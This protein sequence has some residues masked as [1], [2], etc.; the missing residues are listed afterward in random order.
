MSVMQ[1]KE[2]TER[3]AEPLVFGVCAR[4]AAWLGVSAMSVRCAAVI[5]ASAGGFGV[6]VYSVAALGAHRLPVRAARRPLSGDIGVGMV[7]SGVAL[8]LCGSWPGASTAVVVTTIAVLAAV[9]YGWRPI[10]LANR[11]GIGTIMLRVVVGGALMIG[12]A[13]ALLARTDSIDMIATAGVWGLIAVAG[14]AVLAAPGLARLSAAHRSER[15]ARVREAERS[16]VAAHLHDSVLQTLT[17]I[18]RNAGDAQTVSRLARQQ[19]RELRRW[20]YQGDELDGVADWPTQLQGIVDEVEDRY[21]VTIEL[22]MVGGGHI[23]GQIRTACAAAKEAMVNAAKFAETSRVSVFAERTPTEFSVFVRDRGVGFD[24]AAVP[25]TRRGIADSIV[26]RVES[27]GGTALVRSTPGTG[28]EVE[29]CVPL[30]DRAPEPQNIDLADEPKPA[31]AP[32]RVR[33]VAP[34]TGPVEAVRG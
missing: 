8:R 21:A 24:P 1:R 17:L 22:I 18:G 16:A 12:A 32:S 11:D 27:A 30:I 14:V 31:A 7:A 33:V 2:V 13:M 26:R 20:L 15:D 3:Q 4:V 5:L 19:E 9:A 25:S 29:L 10:D 28:T 23:D 6:I 34:S